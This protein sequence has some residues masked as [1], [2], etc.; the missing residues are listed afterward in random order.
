M[1]I[2]ICST[3][4]KQNNLCDG[5]MRWDEKLDDSI[6]KERRRKQNLSN[7][8][9]SHARLSSISNLIDEYLPSQEVDVDLLYDLNTQDEA[10]FLE[11]RQYEE[12][13]LD[14]AIVARYLVVSNLNTIQIEHLLSHPRMCRFIF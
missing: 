2:I 10:A 3:F 6:E 14:T 1:L 5:E 9:Q 4:T 11:A 13:Q 12:K 7:M 8:S